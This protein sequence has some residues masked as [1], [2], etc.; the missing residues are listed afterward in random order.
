MS[1]TAA[2]PPPTT[3]NRRVG[4]PSDLYLSIGEDEDS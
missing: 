1:L 2:A 3:A 4:L